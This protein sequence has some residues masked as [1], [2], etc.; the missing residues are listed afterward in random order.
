[1]NTGLR[2][3]GRLV[4]SRQRTLVIAEIG[5]NHDGS[6]QRALELVRHAANAGADAVKFQIFRASTLVHPSSGLAEY[7]KGRVSED[8]PAR[9]L[10]QYELSMEQLGTIVQA[11]RELRMT[12]L[13][14]PF[15]PEDVDTI[16]ALKLPA[17]KI[18]SPDLVN[19]L[20][21]ARA[22]GTGK[23]LI[24]STG[25]A[26]MQEVEETV[27]WLGQM[28][29]HFVL[30]HCVSSYPTPAY[31]AHLCWINELGKFQCPV[32]YSDHTTELLAGALAVSAGACVIEK[33][34]TYDRRAKGPDHSASADPVEFAEY[35]RLIRMA[36]AM[37]GAGSK[38]VLPIERDVRTVSRQSLVL[39]RDV[40]PG[41]VLKISDLTVQRPGTGIAPADIA[42]AAGRAAKYAL[43]RGTLLQ[44]DMLTDA[45]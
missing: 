28:R 9:M 35:V 17:I 43:P 42:A 30:M 23:P 27:E 8:D 1:M 36:E 40:Q 7:Q 37:R 21:L 24:I 33:H 15:S 26:T 45:A 3:D 34:L 22:A 16:E 5:V 10:R 38:H 31:Q 32:G 11:V 44:W 25:A 41:Q 6:V 14:T 18:A 4:G 20:L 2:I 29:V 13:A 39:A 12:P 19:R